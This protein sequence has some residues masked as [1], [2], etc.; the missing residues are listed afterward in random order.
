M[1]T[2]KQQTDRQRG[3]RPVELPPDSIR[4]FEAAQI[5]LYLFLRK[6]ALDS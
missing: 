3:I 1:T 2:L 6:P 4:L 5:V